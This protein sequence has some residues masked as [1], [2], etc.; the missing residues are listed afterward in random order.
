MIKRILAFI[1]NLSIKYKLFMVFMTII[2]ISFGIFSVLNYFIVGRDVEKQAIYSSNNMLNQTASSLENKLTSVRN[3]M[4]IFAIDETLQKLITK[5]TEF[6]QND[7]GN[8]LIDERDIVRISYA[9]C[10]N[11]GIDNITI[12]MASGLPTIYENDTL[13]LFKR[14]EQR[15]WYN[16][17]IKNNQIY[18]WMK[19]KDID[20]DSTK[21]YFSFIRLISDTKDITKNI[22]AIRADIAEDSI[23][24][25][26]D[27]ARFTKSTV[28]FIADSQNKVISTSSNKDDFSAINLKDIIS[29]INTQ[30]LSFFETENNNNKY[31]IGNKEIEGTD[32]RLVMVIPYNQIH[33]LNIKTL[34]QVIAII[35]II[36]PF[37]LI[38]TLFAVTSNTNRIKKLIYS[39]NK[40]TKKGDFDINIKSDSNDE[41]GQLIE[42]FD[43]MIQKI[44]DLLKEQYLLGKEIKNLE[45]KALQAQINP[46]F[47]YNTLD[48]I[49][50]MA[51]KSGNKDISNIISLLSK[52]YKLSLSKGEDIVTVK[53]EIDHV[54][55]YVTIQ[56][57]RFNNCIKL[58]V[59]VPENIYRVNIPKLTLQPLIENSIIHGILEKNNQSGLISIV[60]EEKQDEVIIY[61]K[62]NGVG[63]PIDRLNE[64]ENNRVIQKEGHGYGVKNINQRL[65]LYFGDNYGLFYESKENVGTTV[66]IVIP[67][68][69]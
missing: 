55:T 8:W 57:Y 56:N 20:P 49:N 34:K 36:T 12:Y 40:V 66:K 51:I 61:V 35:L 4:N 13:L 65:K 28:S 44:K 2:F 30:R 27:M 60:A 38:I 67:K 48:L 54:V 1:N 33:E 43:F 15:P 11:F 3:A 6:Y 10:R 7:I 31:L 41:I 21:N 17:M 59:N 22:A 68:Y 9:A 23:I 45:L 16:D 64:I 52:F 19:L 18:K 24:S 5:T 53:N 29:K 63:I 58:E 25:I 69:F 47:L 26:L 32:W 62:D 37:T 50:W 14:I 39:M 42:A 46:H